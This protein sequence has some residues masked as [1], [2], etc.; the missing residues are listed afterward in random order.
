MNLN[1][2]PGKKMGRGSG[3]A[4]HS[5]GGKIGKKGRA[6]FELINANLENFEAGRGATLEGSNKI[7]EKKDKATMQ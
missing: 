3:K 6:H 4:R 2:G 5:K 7:M 1:A